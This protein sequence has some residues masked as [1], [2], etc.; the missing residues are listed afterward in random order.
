MLGKLNKYSRQIA[1][2]VL[3][4]Y[5]IAR[6][7]RINQEYNQ[8]LVI[9]K[10]P[11]PGLKVSPQQVLAVV[12][13]LLKNV[14]LAGHDAGKF[15]VGEFNAEFG[16]YSKALFFKDAYL[17]MVQRCHLLFMEEVTPKFLQVLGKA[18]GYGHFG[19]P[20]NTR[21]Q[22]VGF[23]VHPRLKLTEKPVLYKQLVDIQGIPD[24]RP[25]L[26]LDLE[27]TTRTMRFSSVVVH[28]KSMRGGVLAT[29]PVR[30][31]QCQQLARLL[32]GSP[33]LAGGDWNTF[34][35]E[36]LDTSPL[37]E[38]GFKLVN[39]GGTLSTQAEGG[40]LD[41]FFTHN[42]AGFKIGSF[43]SFNFWLDSSIGS[44]FSDHGLTMVQMHL[45]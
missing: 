21:G 15:V 6:L 24:L 44:A 23:L 10:Y 12:Q 18:A 45:P 17:E 1:A 9:R 29:A 11:Y 5:Q 27:D 13:R 40:F 20:V 22:G 41:G 4:H 30:Y 16:S 14:K 7:T 37:T 26:R 3:S 25:A 2:S 36:S 38:A 39:P 28:L 33:V 19:S 34:L 8:S 32:D 35:G 31:Q 42:L 43:R